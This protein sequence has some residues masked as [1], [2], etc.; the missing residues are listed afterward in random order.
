MIKLLNKLS[1][2]CYYLGMIKSSV[3]VIFLKSLKTFLAIGI[4]LSFSTGIF[5]EEEKTD[6]TNPTIIENFPTTLTYPSYWHTP[7]GIHRGTAFWLRFFL[8]SGAKFDNP[9]G[10]ACTKL[11]T[12]YGKINEGGDDCQLT[13]YGI[14]S[15]EANIIY[16]QSMSE[17]AMFGGPGKG[18]GQFDKPTGIAC[19][20]YGDVYVADTGNDRV[21]R[22]FNNGKKLKFIRN[23]GGSGN[24]IGLF[25][26]PTYVA[27]DSAG[28]LY[29]SDT[30]N[31]RIQ[32][33]AKSGGFL[34]MLDASNGLLNPTGLCLSD[35]HERYSGYRYDFLYVIDGDNNRILK[36]DL[37]GNIKNAVRVNDLLGK[38]VLL[39]TVA[40]D[41]Y[42]NIYVVDNLNSQLY[43]FTPDLNFITEYGSYG[44]EDYKFE[45]PVGI[46]IYKHYGQVIVSDK[47]SAQYFWIGS[48]IKN[49]IVEKIKNETADMLKFEFTTTEKS[50]VTMEIG[51]EG[52]P[53]QICKKLEL[54]MGENIIT[55]NIPTEDYGKY[56][57]V[58]QTLPIIIKITSTY[59][60]YPHIV[61]QFKTT[62]TF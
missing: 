40:Q 45:N 35:E 27:L 30:G 47:S 9:T 8:G 33:F 14:N 41:Y 56:F 59:S 24:D 39:T 26:G 36:M 23:I 22:L 51:T 55:W 25:R 12:D 13:A 53:V 21:V 61:K 42:G 62:V 2:F 17:L 52:T 50:Y 38:K 6:E 19:N 10:V 11:L 60:S 4:L 44:T 46:A 20:E 48:D 37:Q 54:Q 1:V 18:D 28:R 57:K 3:K 16:N 31:N 5:A 32:V 49:L 58:G 43:K 7:L 34:Y 29:V 15:G